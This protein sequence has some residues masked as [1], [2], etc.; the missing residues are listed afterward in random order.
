MVGV[1]VLIL[2]VVLLLLLILLSNDNELY[3]NG[4]SDAREIKNKTITATTTDPPSNTR[5]P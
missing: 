4:R 2:L 5:A 3:A 1:G